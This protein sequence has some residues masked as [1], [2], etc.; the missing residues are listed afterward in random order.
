MKLLL[1]SALCAI[2]TLI[3]IM[4]DNADTT[5]HYIMYANCKEAEVTLNWKNI[6]GLGVVEG[7]IEGNPMIGKN[8][9]PGELSLQCK[10][11]YLEL[12]KVRHGNK[13]QWQGIGY[14][15][16]DCSE[17]TVELVPTNQTSAPVTNQASYFGNSNTR[18]LVAT[19]F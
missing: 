17:F 3:S 13:F 2:G 12:N 6:R 16:I 11:I 18:S 19:E 15:E 14:N 8:A 7:L 9:R 1:L 4:S 5:K 10:G